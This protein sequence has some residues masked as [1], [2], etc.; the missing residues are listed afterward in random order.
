MA[1]STQQALANDILNWYKGTAFPA[2]NADLYVALLT[3]APSDNAGTGLVECTDGAYARQPIASGGWS[4]IS[5]ASDHAHQQISN[6]AAID[7]PAVS[8][9]AY[10]VNGLALYTALTGGT[11]ME[12]QSVTG[13]SVAT[14]NA[15]TMAIGAFLIQK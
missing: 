8:G 15:Y 4:A 9:T 12:A 5:Q 10:T 14:G 11:L 13:Q 2:A 1:N 7:F 6:S 3:T